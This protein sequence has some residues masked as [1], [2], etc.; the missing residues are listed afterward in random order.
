MKPIADCRLYAFVDT[1]YLSGRRPDEIARQLC[2]GGADLIQL[3]AK[4][5]DNETIL[6][7]AETLLPV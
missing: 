1:A 5:C 2:D 7:I 4:D 6:R 3:R